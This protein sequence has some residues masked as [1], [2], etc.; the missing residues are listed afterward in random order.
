MSTPA[1]YEASST[2]SALRKTTEGICS[3]AGR[4]RTRTAV[5]YPSMMFTLLL[6]LRDL[7]EDQQ[8]EMLV[9]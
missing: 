6:E 5:H 1:G 4:T 8:G 2:T 9:P 7:W 3:Y